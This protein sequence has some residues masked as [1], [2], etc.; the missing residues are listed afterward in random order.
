[1]NNC[2]P[3][4]EFSAPHRHEPG[5]GVEDVAAAELV[6]QFGGGEV[7]LVHA[8]L[9]PVVE[10][11][12]LPL[13][14]VNALT[15][16]RVDHDQFAGHPPRLGDE[17]GALVRQQVTVEMAG[18]HAVELA[19]GEWQR[20]RVPQNDGGVRQPCGGHVDHRRALIEAHHL[21]PQMPG[22]KARAAGD[23]EHPRGRQT[24]DH[25]DQRLHLV[26]PAGAVDV[27]EAAVPQPPV[28]VLPRP[29][30]VVRC[31]SP[32]R[33]CE[34]CS[35]RP[36]SDSDV[37][38]GQRGRPPL[39]SWRRIAAATAAARG[40][41][42]RRPAAGEASTSSTRRSA[43]PATPGADTPASSHP[44]TLGLPSHTRS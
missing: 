12:L 39:A 36:R 5:A 34:A 38:L 2:V 8:V 27:R 11:P 31:A 18:E 40:R 3:G 9:R 15:H 4:T 33:R 10:H 29:P 6:R 26:S 17:G 37:V 30:V 1:M 28:V 13:L 7:A 25:V 43:L 19:V 24:R 21:T 32:R 44:G 35:C 41:R 42:D 20:H 16:R 23:I 14:G 22:Q